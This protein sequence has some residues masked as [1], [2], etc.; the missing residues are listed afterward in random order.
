MY[1]STTRQAEPGDQRLQ[2]AD[3][4][5]VRGDLRDQVVHVAIRGAGGVRALCEDASYERLVEVARAH[6]PD[7]AQQDPL[8][9]DRPARGRH[10]SGRDA[11]YVGVMTAAGHEEVGR[12][13]FT[14][15]WRDNSDVGQ[16]GSTVERVVGCEDVAGLPVTPRACR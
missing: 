6:D 2:L 9:V 3:A 8:I 1:T 7:V 11:P 14:E 10:R 16:M 15:H 13:G 4:V 5:G 12:A